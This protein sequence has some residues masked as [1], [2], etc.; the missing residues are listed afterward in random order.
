M[1]LSAYLL[2]SDFNSDVIIYVGQASGTSKEI[3]FAKGK[4]TSIIHFVLI[5]CRV[6]LSAYF[7]VILVVKY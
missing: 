7:Q 6:F 3:I 5:Y 1:F 4:W 2:Y